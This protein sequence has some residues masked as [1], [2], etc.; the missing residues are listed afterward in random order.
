MAAA[1]VVISDVIVPYDVVQDFDVDYFES[2]FDAE[3]S[4]KYKEPFEKSASAVDFTAKMNQL[5]T[6]EQQ[7]ILSVLVQHT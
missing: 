5:T 7:E 3:T 6:D 2:L 1:N 4:T